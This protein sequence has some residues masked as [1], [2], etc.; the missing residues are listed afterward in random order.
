MLDLASNLWVLR[1]IT[2][3]FNFYEYAIL[4]YIL[5]SWFPKFRENFIGDFL[6][7]ICEPFLSLF[8]KII[9]PIGVLDISPIVA[10][11]VLGLLQRLIISVVFGISFF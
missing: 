10:F 5:L 2:Y 1:F 11:F 3:I 8:R 6:K 4:A 7:T 9:P